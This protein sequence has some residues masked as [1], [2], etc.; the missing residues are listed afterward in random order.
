MKCHPPYN[1]NPLDLMNSV[2]YQVD[3][4]HDFVSNRF[5]RTHNIVYLLIFK[6]LAIFDKFFFNFLLII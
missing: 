6:F 2:T 1:F 3:L 5:E 4:D